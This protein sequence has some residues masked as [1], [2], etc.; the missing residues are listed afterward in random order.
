MLVVVILV[1]VVDIKVNL[2]L[3]HNCSSSSSTICNNRLVEKNKIK[4][5][6]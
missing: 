3:I 2:K 4:L 5:I 6:N 1:V